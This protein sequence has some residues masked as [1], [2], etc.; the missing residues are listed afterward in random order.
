MV[1][2]VMTGM[3]TEDERSD[4]QATFAPGHRSAFIF[5][6]EIW[7]ASKISA[8][9][10]MVELLMQLIEGY[11]CVVGNELDVQLAL[12]EAL[13]NAVVHGNAMN[14]HK[15]VQVRCR[16]E[17]GTGV[18]ITVT[19]YGEGFDPSEVPDPLT[20]ERLLAEHGRGIHLMKSV[21][22]EVSF[23][24]G[25]SEVHMRKVPTRKPETELQGDLQGK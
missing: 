10:P 20:A 14:A 1:V 16:C 12:R 9:S 5:E 17:F 8:I 25:G 13:N 22:D 24:R 7:M 11:R 3:G 4:L 2:A 19:D 21:M 18:Q 6:T 23:K 15:V